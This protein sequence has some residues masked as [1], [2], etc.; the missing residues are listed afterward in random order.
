M[1]ATLMLTMFLA[2]ATIHAGGG[3]Q[4]KLAVSPAHSFAP[5]NLSIRA[6]V[7]PHGENRGLQIVAESAAFYRS[8]QMPLDGEGA[9]GM[10]L[11]EFRSL[12]SGDYR[13][14]GILTA[15]GGRQRALAEQSVTVLSELGH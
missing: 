6:R 15:S 1:K 11:F 7:V 2:L 12:P 14:Y 3:E 9:P 5:S 8:S 4:L 10:L 13:V